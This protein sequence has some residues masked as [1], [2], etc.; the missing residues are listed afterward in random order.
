MPG[1]PAE[2]LR[3]HP[4]QQPG[5]MPGRAVGRGHVRHHQPG[6]ERRG[7]LLQVG[8]VTGAGGLGVG[9]DY[10]HS[11]RRCVPG[12]DLEVLV[13][14]KSLRLPRLR[15]Q[16]Q[17]HQPPG[18]GDVQR[19]GEL[20]HQQVRQHAGE[21]RTRAEHHP[22]RVEHRAHRLG[23]RGRVGRQQRDRPHLT[24]RAGAFRLAADRA[25]LV[26]PVRVG[27]DHFRHDVQRHRGHRQH[28]AAGAEQPA[29]PVQ[30]RDRV[31]EQVPQ[32][33]DEQVAD[34]VAGQLA[35]AA[36]PVLHHLAPGGAP[37]VVPAQRGQRHPQVAGRQD[38]VVAAQPAA[39]PAV[40]SDRH[41]R[42]ELAGHLA[43]R[44][45]RR[46]QPVPA[47]ERYRP[48]AS[49]QLLTPDRGP[50]APPARPLPARRRQG[51]DARR[52]LAG[53]R[54]A[55]VL[56][57]GAAHREGDEPLALTLVAGQHHPQQLRVMIQEL[58]GARLGENV[59]PH[60]R[61]L[62]GHR[63]KFGDPVRVGQEPAV[64]HQ[65]GVDRKAVFVAE[66]DDGQPQ[67]G[68]R[69]AA[70]EVAHPGPQLVHVEPGRVEHQVG[71]AARPAQ[72]LPLGRDAVG[73]PAGALQRVRPPLAVEPAH[74]RVLGSLEVD[75]ARGRAARAE[76]ADRRLQVGAERAA[77]HVDHRGHPDDRAVG[78]GREVD[79]G[80]QQA[81]RQVV[82]HEP[83]QVLERL[84]RG[85]PPRP[86]HAGDDDDVRR[87]VSRSHA[88]LPGLA[89]WIR[90][91][92]WGR[93][94]SAAEMVAASRGPM[95]GH[96]RDLL[97]TRRAELAHRA[98]VLEQGL[99]ARRAEPGHVVER[100]GGGG[101]AALL[102]V[103]GDR[104][105]VRLV[106][107]PLQQVQP[108]AAARQDDR[109]LLAGQPDLLQPL[110]QAADGHVVDAEL[111]Q[112]ARRRLGLQRAA[113][114]DHQVRRIGELLLGGHPGPFG[115]ILILLVRRPRGRRG[116]PA[117]R[118]SRVRPGSGGTGG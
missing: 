105:P 81:G 67:P 104:E 65:V 37:L 1:H 2:N 83:A 53:D 115:L 4:R 78:P 47:T 10:I 15:R 49:L 80:R 29:H 88:L 38:A 64:G 57:A 76:V 11:K 77:A 36:E 48:R 42:G 55:P 54:H 93:S 98:E 60:R 22:V 13:W 70:E 92:A 21:P 61:V 99:A 62:P 112:G 69:A 24:R 5:V 101:L 118:S 89:P 18:R 91:A 110:G 46:R 7:R 52:Q 82:D 28:P 114:D 59:L 12:E 111:G 74:Q 96:R 117:R 25:D 31:A 43:Q 40:V 90:S 68:R 97:D 84:G 16:V 27:A 116:C 6:T 94:A 33:H 86:G 58:R 39:R 109:V 32:R 3:V 106:P 72:Q 19:G 73:D 95:P 35:V 102:P 100:A 17:D 113:V 20:G 75:H 79:H 8:Q 87:V 107:H 34:G 23:H 103:V 71:V 30:A 26:R 66:R 51:G 56:A 44:R 108:L 63:G 9:E 85:G 41:D 45:Q 14:R 50:G